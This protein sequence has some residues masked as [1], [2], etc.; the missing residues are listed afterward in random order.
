MALAARD[1]TTLPAQSTVGRFFPLP[2]LGYDVGTVARATCHLALAAARAPPGA[3]R[4]DATSVIVNSPPLEMSQQVWGRLC[5]GPGATSQRGYSMA[6]GQIHP[7]N[8]S[9]VQPSR[10]A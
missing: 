5:R 4:E 7:L 9:G 2:W 10:E 6:D 3:M 1:K 8:E